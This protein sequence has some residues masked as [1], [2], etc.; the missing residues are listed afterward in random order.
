MKE[1]QAGVALDGEIIVGEIS[2]QEFW[3]ATGRRGPEGFARAEWRKLTTADKAAIA[4]QLRRDGRLSVRDLWAGGWL[5]DR[6]WEDYPD[7]DAEDESGGFGGLPLNL[8][9]GEVMLAPYSDE[10]WAEHARRLA[11]GESVKFMEAQASR[12]NGWGVRA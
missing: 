12:G 7:D 3:M 10:W 5:R 8:A 1:A 2:F 4:D 6:V 11:L 9:V